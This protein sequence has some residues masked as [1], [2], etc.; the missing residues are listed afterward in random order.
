MA[1]VET[2]QKH[3]PVHGPK[4]QDALGESPADPFR[5]LLRNALKSL[6]KR[7]LN[8]IC[9]TRMTWQCNLIDAVTT[10]LSISTI[11][12]CIKSTTQKRITLHLN[13]QIIITSH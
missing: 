7:E 10:E 13:A 8:V 4:E 5:H 6:S 3:L 2:H 9:I 12:G 1:K 11:V